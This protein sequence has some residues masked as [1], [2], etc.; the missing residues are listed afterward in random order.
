MSHLTDG[1]RRNYIAVHHRGACGNESDAASTACWERISCGSYKYFYDFCISRSGDIYTSWDTAC[2][3]YPFYK[4]STGGATCGANCNSA[5]V[6][7]VMMQRCYDAADCGC[8]LQG[9]T[10]PQLCGL[11]YLSL[12]L[13]TGG[14]NPNTYNH[15]NHR[16]AGS[17]NPCGDGC[18]TRCCGDW[19]WSPPGDDGWN[20]NG[21]EQM[22]RM[23]WMRYNLSIGC[24]CT[25]EICG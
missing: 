9:F 21:R 5:S 6:T 18:S 1:A 20:G 2:L 10:D 3:S 14:S 8:G 23:L 12:H 25:G 17:W 22:N 16:K 4:N 7:A 13:G 11:G 15:I 19:F 24:N